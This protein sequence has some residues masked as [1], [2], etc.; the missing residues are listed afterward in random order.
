VYILY[1]YVHKRMYRQSPNVFSTL[2]PSFAWHIKVHERS[3]GTY[4]SM[5]STFKFFLNQGFLQNA[6]YKTLL[7]I[8][9]KSAEILSFAQISSY[10]FKIIEIS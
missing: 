1:N 3:I 5:Y 7:E 6:V 4:S 2:W 9:K 8:N 10:F